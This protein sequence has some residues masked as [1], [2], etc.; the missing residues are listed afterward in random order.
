M[1]NNLP[2]AEQVKT[3]FPHFRIC[4]VRVFLALLYCIITKSTTNLNKCK[5]A[6]GR[7]LGDTSINLDSAYRRL[8]RFFCM[9][10]VLSF[11]LGIAYLIL[12]TLL[13]GHG[14]AYLAIDRTNWQ[15]GKKPYK[16][17]INLLVIGLVLNNGC[18][19]PLVWQTLDKRGNSSQQERIDLNQRLIEL[20]QPFMDKQKQVFC[21]LGDREF[22]GLDW[23]EHLVDKGFNFV[24]RLRKDDYLAALAMSQQKSIDKVSRK[25]KRKVKKRGYFCSPIELNGHQYYYIVLPNTNQKARDKYVR[26]LTNLSDVLQVSQ[27]YTERWQIEVFFKHCK[28]N[29]FNLE[30]MNM[31]APN[32]AMLMMAVVSYAYILAIREGII[33]E[34]RKPMKLQV[35]AKTK[36]VYRR[37]SVFTVGYEILETKLMSFKCLGELIVQT[38]TDN[39]IINKELL[40]TYFMKQQFQSVQ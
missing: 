2:T 27:A 1:L 4:R 36:K 10:N 31:K 39:T 30:D 6:F 28:T 21:F 16:V 35:D 11:C 19:I 5:K 38:I 15:I 22:I 23:F 20:L 33:K 26:F 3:Y 32:K 12:Q 34:K 17:N 8:T 14:S 13:T 18:F 24:M 9:E 7:G 29:G 25:I 37:V 40:M